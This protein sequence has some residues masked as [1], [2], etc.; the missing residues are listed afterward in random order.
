MEEATCCGEIDVSFRPEAVITR[1]DASTW[2][3]RFEDAV[4]TDLGRQPTIRWQLR[5]PRQGGQNQPPL[6]SGD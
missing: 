6:D 4:I 1:V 3:K 2:P 5:P